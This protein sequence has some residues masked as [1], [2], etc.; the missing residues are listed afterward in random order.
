M[1]QTIEPYGFRC[2]VCGDDHFALFGSS[3]SLKVLTLVFQP[4]VST[5]N[6]RA[7]AP[8]VQLFVC[9]NCINTRVGGMEI[10]PID[11]R[12][13]EELQNDFNFTFPVPDPKGVDDPED[14]KETL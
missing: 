9:V 4:R 5:E 3:K 6:F 11:F 13:G 12:I 14:A 10:W 2:V 1:A 8:K 7:N